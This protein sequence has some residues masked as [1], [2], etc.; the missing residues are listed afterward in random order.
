MNYKNTY[1]YWLKQVSNLENY[2]AMILISHVENHI[3]T[4]YFHW[5]ERYEKPVKQRFDFIPLQLFGYDL[6]RNSTLQ[7]VQYPSNCQQKENLCI[8]FYSYFTFYLS[9]KNKQNHV[10]DKFDIKK[11]FN[12]KIYRPI[13]LR[14]ITL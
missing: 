14:P 1:I 3:S 4:S 8:L 11:P 10:D 12:L 6:Y 2:W 13:I 9:L 7:K 5:K